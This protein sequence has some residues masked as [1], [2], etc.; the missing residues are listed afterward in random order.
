M[1]NSIIRNVTII[2]TAFVLII[3]FLSLTREPVY[4]TES[5]TGNKI[6]KFQIESLNNDELIS[7]K[8][9]SK[10]KYALINFWASWC[11]PCRLEHEKLIELS[12]SR[13]LTIFGVNFKDKKNNA[14]KYLDEMGNPYTYLLKD[15]YGKQSVKFG[16]Y[17][18]PES[19]LVDRNLII[20]KKVIGPL[21]DV[22]IKEISDLIMDNK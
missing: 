22:D 10:K 9:I 13:D 14:I 6:T 8:E 16:I 18:I 3:F 11:A 7:Y 20:K 15:P 19:I 4:N 17:G 2:I 1:R 21:T 5:L 12:K